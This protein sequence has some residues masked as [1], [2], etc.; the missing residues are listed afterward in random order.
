MERWGGESQVAGDGKEPGE[1]Q[2][3]PGNTCLQCPRG[4]EGAYLAG[5]DRQFGRRFLFRETLGLHPRVSVAGF[6]KNKTC[7]KKLLMV[8][9][10]NY[11][12]LLKWDRSYL[13]K[14]TVQNLLPENIPPIA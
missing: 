12:P 6:H 7:N 9:W 13:F 3:G 10:A 2:P 8:F 14:E 11:F 4:L 1:S 5:A